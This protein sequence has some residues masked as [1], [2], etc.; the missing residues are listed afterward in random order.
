M[1][2]RC[3]PRIA[4]AGMERGIGQG[5]SKTEEGTGRQG[6]VARE[7]QGVTQGTNGAAG[8]LVR[9]LDPASGGGAG[10]AA[11]GARRDF[12]LRKGSCL[13]AAGWV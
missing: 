2:R 12:S 8:H 11:G 13:T 1:T 5:C 6:S 3:P 4:D 7:Q 10:T 9:A